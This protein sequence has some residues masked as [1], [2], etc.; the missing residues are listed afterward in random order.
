[1]GVSPSGYNETFNFSSVRSQAAM[2]MVVGCPGCY[3][4]LLCFSMEKRLDVGI[5]MSPAISF[6]RFRLK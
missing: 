6:T 1:M 2:V 3:F 5:G 4:L